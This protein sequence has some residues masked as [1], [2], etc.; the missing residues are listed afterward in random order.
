MK[1]VYLA[2]GAAG[3]YCGSC[4][5]DNTLAAALLKS[6]HDVALVPTYT[7][8]RTDEE[9]VSQKRVFFGGINVFLQQKS[10]LFRHTPWMFDAMFDSPKLIEWA[11]RG[12]PSVDAA[13]LGD[14]TVSMLEGERGHQAKELRKLVTWLRSEQPDIVHLSNSM[15]LGMARE[16]A[17]QVAP[18]VCTLSG[19]DIFLEKLTEPFYTEA[20]RLLR[21]CAADVA[22]FVALNNYY[23]DYMAEYLSVERGRIEVIPHGLNLEGH[24]RRKPREQTQPARAGYFARICH[25]KGLHLLVEAVEKLHRQPGFENVELVAAGYLSAGDRPYLKQ[26]EERVR[27]WPDPGR[28]HYHGELTREEK[29]SFLQSLDVMAVPTVYRESKGISVLEA[30]ANGVPIVVPAHGTFP[31]MVAQTGGGVLHEPNDI[32]SLADQLQTVLADR[33]RAQRLGQAGY[34]AVRRL[35]NSEQ[36]ARKTAAFYDSI[37]GKVAPRRTID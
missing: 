16:I 15:L 4:L 24:G 7:P 26:I 2:A 31:E 22:G 14:L 9:D 37:L 32:S 8:I 33:E 27:R 12:G 29:I 10:A 23:A 13:R 25:D 28:F 30:L 19:E 21:A 6:G 5:H 3:M 35:H 20:R 1:I 17:Q 18:V 11:T 34:E 36:M